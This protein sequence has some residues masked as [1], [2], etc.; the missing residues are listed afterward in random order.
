[1]ISIDEL[2]TYDFIK[3]DW[4]DDPI[5]EES[6][7]T[8]AKSEDLGGSLFGMKYYLTIVQNTSG[9]VYLKFSADYDR[10]YLMPI[11]SSEDL[12]QL[13][14]IYFD[15]MPNIKGTGPA[16]IRAN[17]MLEKSL[18]YSKPFKWN[19]N[20]SFFCG[21]QIDMVGIENT[22]TFNSFIHKTPLRQATAFWNEI[23]SPQY[24]IFRTL[25]SG[26]QFIFTLFDDVAVEID[27]DSYVYPLILTINYPGNS[28]PIDCQAAIDEYS[29]KIRTIDDVV[30]I[31][32]DDP[33]LGEALLN[34]MTKIDSQNNSQK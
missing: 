33:E 19:N 20:M 34:I 29:F 9:S 24:S 11:N 28:L 13:M 12:E 2:R 21:L 30:D 16:M 3:F 25:Y 1:M 7:T 26:S 15:K 8:L 27:D 31:A 18:Y 14:D 6:Y 5:L 22:T 10:Q 23:T 32:K 17:M 4:F